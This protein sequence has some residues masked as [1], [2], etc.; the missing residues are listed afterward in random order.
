MMGLTMWALMLMGWLCRLQQHCPSSS[1]YPASS[2]VN[3][4][5]VTRTTASNA[6]ITAASWPQGAID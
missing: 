6:T 1:F 4:E 2:S 3:R 5:L